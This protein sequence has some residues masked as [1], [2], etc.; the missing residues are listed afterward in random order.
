MPEC[1][2]DLRGVCTGTGP[3]VHTP[4]G[5]GPN[6]VTKTTSSLGLGL[7]ARAIAKALMRKGFTKQ[8]AIATA[9]ATVKRW[10]AGGGKVTPATRARAAKEVEHWESLKARNKAR[11]MTERRDMTRTVD[12]SVD[13]ATRDAA[14]RAGLTF[15]GTTSY[16]LADGSGK[17]SRT[18]ASRAVRMVGLGNVASKARIRAWLVRKLRAHGAADLIPSSW[19]GASMS[20]RYDAWGNQIV[21]LADTARMKTQQNTGELGFK[22]WDTGDLDKMS[23][24][25]LR[26][27]LGSSIRALGRSHPYTRKV[28]SHVS[29]RRRMVSRGS[30]ARTQRS[31]PRRRPD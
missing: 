18:L 22:Q 24:S 5:P 15:P 14:R 4:I 7:Y 8:R 25:T 27:H 30:T 10:A 16:P 9:I 26:T 23:A 6:W 12:L 21:E 2:V 1:V 31:S 13:Q 11:H 19:T 29:R 28:A 17:F 3:C 20:N